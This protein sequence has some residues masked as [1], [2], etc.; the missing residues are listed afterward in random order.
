MESKVDKWDFDKLVPVPVDFSKLSDAVKN[1]VVKK[2]I[3]MLTS[4]Q[5]KIEY[6]ILLTYTNTTTVNATTKT[7]FNV[8]KRG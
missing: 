7:N 4:K 5:L 6:L 1:N 2:D 8:E 3:L